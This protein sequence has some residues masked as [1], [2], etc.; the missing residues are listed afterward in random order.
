MFLDA[1]AIIAIIAREPEEKLLAFRLQS[2]SSPVLVSPLAVFEA[3]TGLA[4]K[5]AK[6]LGGKG[7]KTPPDLLKEINQ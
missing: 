4:R 3:V 6:R 1:S 5:K 7:A 2:A